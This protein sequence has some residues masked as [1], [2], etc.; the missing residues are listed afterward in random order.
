MNSFIKSHV[1]MTVFKYFPWLSLT[2]WNSQHNI[3]LQFRFSLST[4]AYSSHLV[5]TI[6]LPHAWLARVEITRLYDVIW[7]RNYARSIATRVARVRTRIRIEVAQRM[8]VPNSIGF[9]RCVLFCRNDSF[10]FPR[11]KHLVL[12]KIH[13][14]LC[15]CFHNVW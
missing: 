2:I 11:S 12:L 5:T 15:I 13:K 14:I 7:V 8:L 4:F 3:P 6:I 9:L 1:F 10:S